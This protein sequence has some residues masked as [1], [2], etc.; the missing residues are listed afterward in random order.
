FPLCKTHYHPNYFVKG[1]ESPTAFQEYYNTGILQFIHV[2]TSS[3]VEDK[4]CIYFES[5]MAIKC[6]V[7][8]HGEVL[9][10][11]HNGNHKNH[12]NQALQ[13]Q[14]YRM[15]GTGQPM[16]SYLCDRCMTMYKG[17]DV[18]TGVYDGVSVHC[19]SCSMHDCTEPL[20]NQRACYCQTHYHLNSI[21]YIKGCKTQV[22]SGFNTYSEPSYRQHEMASEEKN[23]AMFQLQNCLQ[24]G[25]ISQVGPVYQTDVSVHPLSQTN[26]PVQFKTGEPATSAKVKGKNSGNW[27]NNKQLFVCRCRVIISHTTFFGSE[28]ITG[29]SHLMASSDPYFDKVGLPVDIWHFKCKHKEGNIFCQVHCNPVR[30]KELIGMDGE[31][32]IFNSSAVEQSNSW[33]GKFQ[34]IVQEMAIS[35]FTLL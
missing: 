11:P 19:V 6:M 14:N 35:R 13:E 10:V 22:E 31:T 2:I 27:T 26:E 24:Q 32:W 16:W 5:Q 12:L 1:T 20:R 7:V 30:F 4:L 8:T 17:E 23:K 29:V 28:G 34:T 3:F 18:T 9:S 33:F 21:C 15:V 25:G